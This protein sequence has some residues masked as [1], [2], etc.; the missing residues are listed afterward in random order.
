[1]LNITSLDFDKMQG[2]LPVCVQD[3]NTLQVLM[4]SF[5]NK[6]A[7]NRTIETRR[8]TF[9]SRTKRRLWTKGETS[10]NALEVVN[11][12]PDCDNDSLLIYARPLG[13]TCHT[14]R[15]TCFAVTELPSLY[16]FM[17]LYTM[18]VDRA[19]NPKQGSYTSELI[20]RGVG[21]VAQKVGEEAVEVAIAAVSDEQ[22]LVVGEIVDLLYHVFVLLVLKAIPINDIVNTIRQRS[23]S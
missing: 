16:W 5:M 12:V 8:V 14:G 7:L 15:Y 22:Q 10:G 1:M 21:R 20:Q 4:L 2:L 13:P 9:F 18:I 23:E 17:Q 3:Y 19:E 6:E 11:I